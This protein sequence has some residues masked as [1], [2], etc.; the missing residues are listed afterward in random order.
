MDFYKGSIPIIETDKAA[1]DV[2]HPPGASFGMVQRDYGKYPQSMFAPPDQ[3]QIIPETEWDARFDEQEAN[4]SSLEH[5]Y[6]SGP[7]GEPA[8]INLDQNGKPDCWCYSTGHSIMLDELKQNLPV[9]RLN[10]HAVAVMLKENNG[11]WCGLSAKFARTEG[12]PEDGTASGQWPGFSM[13]LSNDTPALRANMGMRKIE[14]DWVDLTT[15]VYD[16]NLTRGQ[17]ATCG[18]TNVPVPSD[19]NWWS[20]SVCQVRWVRIEKGSWGPLILNSWLN[21]GRFG[22]AV[23]RGSQATCNG[24]VATRLT[25]A[26]AA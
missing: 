7:N 9:K 4:K 12:Y 21:W 17:V 24:A 23:L 2:S 18:F 16:Q 6:L 14:E 10:P 20:H 3:L 15:Q 11:G 8:F 26:L 13:S 1:T 22:L 25:S 5:I 19:F